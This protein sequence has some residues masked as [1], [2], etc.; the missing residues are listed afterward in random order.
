MLG[1]TSIFGKRRAKKDFRNLLDSQPLPEEPQV[2][3]ALSG[4]EKTLVS[5][6]T[7]SH[8]TSLMSE[9]PK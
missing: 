6:L 1:L 2:Q 3:T 4:F 8:I 5:E 9:L 7:M